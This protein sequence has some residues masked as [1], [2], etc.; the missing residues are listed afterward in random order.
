MCDF[1]ISC[2]RLRVSE[3]KGLR[4]CCRGSSGAHPPEKGNVLPTALCADA[5]CSDEVVTTHMGST[6]TA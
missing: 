2:F 6:Y 5:S 1:V 4:E 3:R